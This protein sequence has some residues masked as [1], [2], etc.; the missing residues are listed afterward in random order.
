MKKGNDDLGIILNAVLTI[1]IPIALAGIWF[2]TNVRW[3][4]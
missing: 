4:E 2:M 3:W 1:L